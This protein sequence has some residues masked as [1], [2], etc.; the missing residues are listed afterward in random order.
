MNVSAIHT[1]YCVNF[2]GINVGR[3]L[4]KGV[5]CVNSLLKKRAA[6]SYHLPNNKSAKVLRGPGGGSAGDTIL[7]KFADKGEHIFGLNILT[8]AYR[9]ARAKNSVQ[10]TQAVV[11]I[12]DNVVLQPVK[13]SAALSVAAE[14]AAI[15]TAI[16]PGIGT[17]IGATVGYF[18]TFVA[19]SKTRNAIVKFFCS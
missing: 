17:A 19:W 4:N 18:G 6:G 10:R 5:S 3:G 14:G 16:C 11:S 7:E 12:A 8:G 15:G 1:P 9:A 2:T 13:Q